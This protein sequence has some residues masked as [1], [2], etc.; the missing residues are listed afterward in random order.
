[1]QVTIAALG[2]IFVNVFVAPAIDIRINCQ[3]WNT[4][5]E[6]VQGAVGRLSVAGIEEVSDAEGWIYFRGELASRRLPIRSSGYSTLVADKTVFLPNGRLILSEHS[7]QKSSHTAW[8]FL[9]FENRNGNGSL[10]L[11]HGRFPCIHEKRNSLGGGITSTASRMVP[12]GLQATVLDT[13]YVQKEGYHRE[14]QFVFA[15]NNGKFFSLVPLPPPDSIPS[16]MVHVP[17]GEFVMGSENGDPDETP[18]RKVHLSSFYMDTVEVTQSEYVNL[19]GVDPWNTIDGTDRADKGGNYPAWGVNWFDAVVFCNA[20][21][22]AH[23]RDTVYT[24]SSIEG[25]LGDGCRLGGVEIHL[26]R[27]GFR[28]PTEA[29]WEYACRAGSNTKYFWGSTLG[30]ATE[31]AWYQENSGFH[32][33]PVGLKETNWFGLHDIIGNV[34][35]WTNDTGD[36][37]YDDSQTLNPIDLR[38]SPTRV[39]RGGAFPSPGGLLRSTDRGGNNAGEGRTFIGFRTVLSDW[40]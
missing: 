35:E 19:L 21:S 38:P 6:P 10:G 37:N 36:R 29:E 5:S 8:H 17:E 26:D 23:G 15:Y 30:P 12:V 14:R 16:G 20:K 24:W 39:A 7:R 9:A 18:I 40:E 25:T 27:R 32:A 3:V 4:D 11:C 1:M 33:H 34:Y 28:L 13:V 2:L 31:Y 22:K